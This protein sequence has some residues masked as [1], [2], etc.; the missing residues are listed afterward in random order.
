MGVYC[1]IINT[2]YS[3]SKK[4]S[5]VLNQA[6]CTGA[7]G[8]SDTSEAPSPEYLVAGAAMQ[9]YCF[10]FALNLLKAISSKAN[11]TSYHSG[12]ADS[13]ARNWCAVQQVSCQTALCESCKDSKSFAGGLVSLCSGVS[14]AMQA[15]HIAADCSSN[16]CAHHPVML[17]CRCQIRGQHL[18]PARVFSIMA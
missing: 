12:K 16:S 7:D 2:T 4:L 15:N 17:V 8:A 18:S 10:P 11:I 13:L 9:L 6:E 5:V 1:L 3:W 14:T